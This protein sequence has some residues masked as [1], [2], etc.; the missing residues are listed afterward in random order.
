MSD[1]RQTLIDAGWKQGAILQPGPFGHKEA[2]GFLVLNQTCDCVNSDFE[3]EPYLELLPLVK[4]VGKPNSRIKNGENPRQ[5]QFQMQENGHGIWVQS[6]ITEAFQFDRAA[7]A[8]LE[9]SASYRLSQTSLDDLIRWRAQRYVRT[10]FPDSFEGAFGA[11]HENFRKLVSKHESLIDS[12][13]L[14][15]SPFEEIEEGDCYQIQLRLMADPS[16]MAQPELAERL[17]ELSEK[18]EKL[19]A[20][21][22]C[23]DHPRCRVFGLDEMNLWEARRFVD[24]TRYDYLSFGKEEESP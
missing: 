21:S 18:I 19:F 24:F 20:E 16:I 10:A 12:L 11:I 22:A 4:V 5:I 15:L 8:S 17:H 7:H 14:S 13:L 23:F 3:K 1:L 2:F 9:F 6:K